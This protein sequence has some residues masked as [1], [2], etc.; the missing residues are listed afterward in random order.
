MQNMKRALV[1]AFQRFLSLKQ[2]KF[3]H[4]FIL[5]SGNCV[6]EGGVEPAFLRCNPQDIKRQSVAADIASTLVCLLF[7]VST[8]IIGNDLCTI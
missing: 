5:G 6:Y 8:F 2:N 3:Y 7:H 1:F 4:A